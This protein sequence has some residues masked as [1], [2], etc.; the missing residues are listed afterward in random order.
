MPSMQDALARIKDELS[1][2]VPERLITSTCRELGHVWRERTLTP[3]VTTYLLVQQVL[4]GNVAISHLRHLGGLACSD[5]A[6][7]QARDRLPLA[8]LRRLQQAVA[9]RMPAGEGLWRGRRVWMVDGSSF[10]MP[11]TAELQETFGQPGAQKAGCGF[12]VAHLLVLFDL[13]GGFLR[14][15]VPAPLRTHDLAAAP[16]VHGELAAGDVLLGDRAFGSFAH[17]ALLRQRGLHGVFRAHQR[18]AAGRRPRKDRRVNY[19]KPK[20]R[21]RW[22]SAADYAALP[23]LLKVREVRYDIRLP[24]RRTRRVSLV[25]T[26]L[27]RRRYPA[28]ALAALYGRRQEVE[29]NLRHLKQTLGLDALRCQT[30]PGVVKELTAFALVYNLVRRVMTAAAAKQGVAA[31]RVSFVDALRWLR[32]ARPGEQV[33]RLKV[34]PERP[35]RAEPR[36]RKR[37]P[38]QFPV[39]KRPRGQL[40]QALFKQRPAA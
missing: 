25:T 11:D 30:V 22:L 7:C 15:A 35:G 26:L 40:R 5:S 37:R 36:V 12:P 23:P 34:N 16:A 14:K 28:A 21:P 31:E 19:L 29:T 4:Q 38:K 3:V 8:V 2:L 18:R 10:S 32:T 6:Y 24:G 1:D 13:G 20:K 9:G 27:D 39:M 33:P 17:L